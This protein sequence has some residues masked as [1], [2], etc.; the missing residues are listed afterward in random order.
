MLPAALL[1]DITVDISVVILISLKNKNILTSYTL[2]MASE[3]LTFMILL[4]I[5]SHLIKSENFKGA[6][7]INRESRSEEDQ[8]GQELIT[9][10][11]LS[12][13]AKERCD[14]AVYGSDGICSFM[15]LEVKGPLAQSNAKKWEKAP[16]RG[17]T[18]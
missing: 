2:I 3:I 9:V 5:F 10:C 6:F 12:C 1:Q 17:N 18:L 16:V 11:L 13:L 4:L 7:F 15:D 14:T 8:I